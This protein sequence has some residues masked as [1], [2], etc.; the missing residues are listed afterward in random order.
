MVTFLVISTLTA[1][2]FFLASASFSSASAFKA[3]LYPLALNFLYL[4]FS[5]S[6]LY[7]LRAWASSAAFLSAIFFNFAFS[8]LCFSSNSSLFYSSCLAVI[9]SH[10]FSYTFGGFSGLLCLQASTHLSTIAQTSGLISSWPT[11][12]KSL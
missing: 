7:S 1:S 9:S 5:S 6:A 12:L 10:G 2:A 3:F 8:S 4:S 11:S